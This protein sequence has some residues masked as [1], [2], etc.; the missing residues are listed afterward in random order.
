MQNRRIWAF[1]IV[2][3]LIAPLFGIVAAKLVGGGLTFLKPINPP[4]WPG[5]VV[6]FPPLIFLLPTMWR[7]P[8]AWLVLLLAG[9]D[10]DRSIPIVIRANQRSG[11]K[12]HYGLVNV[13]LWR[14]RG[15][16]AA[17]SPSPKISRCS[18]LLVPIWLHEG[19]PGA[20]LAGPPDRPWRSQ[21]S[22][23]S[24]LALILGMGLAFVQTT[25]E[26]KAA[27]WESY[28]PWYYL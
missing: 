1:A 11:G 27:M 12:I 24:P 20:L 18:S 10:L 9:H 19:S 13:P 22:P 4:S 17:L 3:T 7:W 26:I 23:Y 14:K 21:S 28:R 25:D 16:R 6:L 8:R 5:G 15:A 2:G